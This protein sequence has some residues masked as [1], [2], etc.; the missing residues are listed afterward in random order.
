MPQFR[1]LF[2]WLLPGLVIASAHLSPQLTTDH[3]VIWPRILPR[4]SKEILG[5]KRSWLD[6]TPDQKGSLLGHS[7]A[8]IAQFQ[9]LVIH[10]LPVRHPRL[11]ERHE[12]DLARGPTLGA[13]E[14]YLE[15]KISNPVQFCSNLTLS[16]LSQRNF[17]FCAFLC[18]NTPSKCPVSTLLIHIINFNK[19]GIKNKVYKVN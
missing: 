7:C 16:F 10:R 15:I 12:V 2:V 13:G 18:I 1:G 5:L 9:V 6:P 11:V 8:G 14:E 17:N 4:P 3:R 19:E